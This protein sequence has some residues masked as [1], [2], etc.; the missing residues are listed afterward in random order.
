MLSLRI[1]AVLLLAVACAPGQS[2]TYPDSRIPRTKDGKPNLTAPAPRLNGKPD[3]SGLWQVER[4]PERDYAKVLGAGFSGLQVDLHDINKNVMNIFWGLK[5]DEE[6]LRPEGAA[7]YKLASRKPGYVSAHAVSPSRRSRGHDGHDFQ[8][9][10]SAAGDRDSDGAQF[11]TS[12]DL[13]RWP[14]HLKIP[15]IP[16]WVLRLASGRATRWWWRPAV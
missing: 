9:P 8:D 5:P 15:N 14:P 12:S 1:S 6:P 3:L 16:G 10:A 13:H 11:T 4:T 2:L 7:V